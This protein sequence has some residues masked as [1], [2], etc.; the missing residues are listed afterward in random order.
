MKHSIHVRVYIDIMDFSSIQQFNDSIA[1]HPIPVH[2][3][4]KDLVSTNIGHV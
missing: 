2:T 4:A 1:W 3:V